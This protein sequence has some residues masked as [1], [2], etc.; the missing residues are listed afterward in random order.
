MKQFLPFFLLLLSSVS[1]AQTS[2]YGTFYDQ[3][4]SL[5]EILPDTK[6]EIIFLGNSITNFCEWGELFQNP[7]VKNRGISGDVTQGVLDRLDEVTRAKPA[8]VFLLIGI[9]DLSRNIPK[10]TV[11]L[12]ITKI[13]DNI[14]HASPKTRIYLQ[15]ILP[16]NDR[17]GL[18]PNHTNKTAEIKWINENLVSLCKD[19]GYTFVDLYSHFKNS[20]D[21]KMNPEYT[22]DGL[23][24]LGKGYLLWANIIKPLL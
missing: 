4:K 11:L 15:S 1:F 6:N 21:D 2:K 5:F 12:N 16:V 14:H 8:K 9:N 17:F 19:K 20:N 7:H 18:F 23:H 13:A 24:L 22:N 10:D 3:R